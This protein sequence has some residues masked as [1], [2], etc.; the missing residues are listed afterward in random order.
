[1]AY[2]SYLYIADLIIWLLH[3]LIKGKIGEIYNVGSDKSVSLKQLSNI[4]VKVNKSK[5]KV[6][7]V[8]Q[9]RSKKINYYIPNINLAKNKLNLKIWT[10]LNHSIDKTTSWFKSQQ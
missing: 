9:N 10:D 2:R 3:I 1:M 6:I 5:S 7:S 4:I 8:N